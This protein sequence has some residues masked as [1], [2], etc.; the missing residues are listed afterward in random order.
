MSYYL[1]VGLQDMQPLATIRGWGDVI[2]W[3]E[4]LP[5]GYDL[6]QGLCK[7]GWAGSL[8]TLTKQVQEALKESAPSDAPT[9]A[10]VVNLLK[11]LKARDAN[12]QVVSVTDG[13]A[14]E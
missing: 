2:R 4:G 14:K 9:R 7:E 13:W 11:M 12:A 8:P 3:A 5:E 6:I 10:T 1:Q